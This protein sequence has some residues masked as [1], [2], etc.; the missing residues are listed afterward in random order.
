MKSRPLGWFLVIMVALVTCNVRTAR[1]LENPVD[2]DQAERARERYED[3][4][5]ELQR[6]APP[7]SDVV[8]RSA[9]PTP[10]TNGQCF[11]IDRIDADGVTVLEPVDLATAT[12]PFIGQCLG[13]KDLDRVIDA[14]N[15]LYIDHGY[16]TAR[17]YLPQQDLSTGTLHLTVVEGTTEGFAFQG[18][19]ARDELAMALPRLV[20]ERLNLRDVEQGLEQMN[21]LSGWNAKIQ[22]APGTDTGTSTVIIEQPETPVLHGELGIDNFGSVTTGR[23]EAHTTLGWDDALGLLDSWTAEYQ[24]NI[25]APGPSH[26]STAASLDFSIPYGYWTVVAGFH[27]SDYHYNI[28]G[29]TQSFAVSGMT[30]RFTA[31]LNRV[32]SRS[33]TGKTSLELGYELK[34]EKSFLQ[35]VEIKTQSQDLAAADLRLSHTEALFGGAWYSTWG[36]K[37]GFGGFGTSL[38]GQGPVVS[39][40]PH[41]QYVKFSYDLN[42][43]QPIDLFGQAANWNP[44]LHLETSHPTLFG[45]ERLDIG[46]LYTVRGFRDL[47]VIGERGGYLRNDLV[48]ALPETDNPLLKELVPRSELYVGLDGGV[49]EAAHKPS[50][51]SG[52]IAGAAAGIRGNG[53]PISFDGS[54]AHGLSYGPLTNEG[55]LLSFQ[56]S[57]IF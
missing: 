46:S 11:K 42:G 41:A 36:L 33:Q 3:R 55:W 39:T 37:R 50:A 51:T 13:L 9:P 48:F 6:I 21:R 47:S 54:V 2:P 30:E 40:G 25:V 27:Y 12:G 14:V 18:R 56:L 24:R 5:R 23:T 43:Y 10:T 38:D 4:Q 45:S 52:G 26:F 34:R 49:A 31:S 15:G 22:I 19:D 44:T 53:G 7:D 20:G 17:A 8:I 16:V 57:A 35:S 29:L 28:V 32:L 1:A